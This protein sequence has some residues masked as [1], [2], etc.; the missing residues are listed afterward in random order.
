M[1]VNSNLKTKDIKI[2][3]ITLTSSIQNLIEVMSLNISSVGFIG[4][5]KI[6]SALARGLLASGKIGKDRITASGP[7]I[8]D[9]ENIKVHFK[10]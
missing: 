3:I 2:T 5:G 8:L 9:T 4:A 10:C 6:A 1:P 7:S